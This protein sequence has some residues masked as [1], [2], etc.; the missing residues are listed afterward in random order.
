MA[1]G[2]L[3]TPSTFF[4]S[5]NSYQFSGLLLE[6]DTFQIWLSVA[7]S[8]DPPNQVEYFTPPATDMFVQ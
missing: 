8:F 3:H 1:L 4:E 2:T 5:L 6:K 7:P